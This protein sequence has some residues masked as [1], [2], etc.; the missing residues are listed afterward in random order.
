MAILDLFSTRQKRGRGGAP[1]V[2]VYDQLPDALRIQIIYILVDAIGAPLIER[3]ATPAA[4]VYQGIVNDLRRH[5][6]IV[7][8]ADGAFAHEQLGNFLRSEPD[9]GRCLDAIELACRVIGKID[10][11]YENSVYAK[12][13]PDEAIA[14]LNHRFLEHGVGYQF[15]SG[16]IVKTDSQFLH[17]EVIKPA[18]ALLQDRRYQGAN[19]EFLKAHE[20]YRKGEVK[21]CLANCL[22][23]LESTLKAICKIRDWVSQP[24]DTP[25][26]L[27]DTCFKNNLVPAFFQSHYA[28]LKST[29]E[30]G[31]PTVRNKLGGH[32]QGSQV[33]TVPPHY[34]AYALH[35]TGSAIQFLIEAEKSLP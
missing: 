10:A 9:V 24:T 14:D 26:T 7:A 28:A 31:V 23:A 13:K 19:D 29:L 16:R 18:L 1:D 5:F 6:G 30:S 2:F 35:M 21:E 3:Y 12:L 33:V 11:M 22:K 4:E 17:A 8:L 34:A 32:G 15:L 25:K 27:L 20:H